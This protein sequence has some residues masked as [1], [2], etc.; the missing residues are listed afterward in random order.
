MWLGTQWG[1]GVRKRERGGGIMK[2][3]KVWDV[4]LALNAPIYPEVHMHESV[5]GD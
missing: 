3:R 5:V 1:I 4:G 2:T